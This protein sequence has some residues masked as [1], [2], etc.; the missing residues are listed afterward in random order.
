VA[1]EAGLGGRKGTT[2]RKLDEATREGVTDAATARPVLLA[3]PSLIKR[4][5]VDW[6][7]K[8]P[9][10]TGFDADAWAAVKAV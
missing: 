3:N 10:T 7:P 9:V 4:P 6:G 1:E 2:W 5:V 8:N